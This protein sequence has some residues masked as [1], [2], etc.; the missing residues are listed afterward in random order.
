M[1]GSG[2]V[3]VAA[4]AKAMLDQT[5]VDAVMI[6]RGAQGNPWVF[7]EARSLLDS[8][9]VIPRPGWFERIDMAREHLAA[10]LE[11]DGERAYKRMTKHVVW[12]VSGMPGATYFRDRV[13]SVRSSEQLDALI[14][15]Y[16][17]FLK[18]RIARKQAR[19]DE[20]AAREFLGD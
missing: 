20:A 2:D 4:D 19:D 6:A 5:G 8:G 11:F 3:M 18:M 7:R 1:V 12:Y 14:L 9:E 15:E 16:A 13:F 10:M 17:E